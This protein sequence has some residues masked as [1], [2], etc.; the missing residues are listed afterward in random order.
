MEIITIVLSAAE[1]RTFR[2]RMQRAKGYWCIYL[3]ILYFYFYRTGVYL[4]TRLIEFKISRHTISN[5]KKNL[6]TLYSLKAFMYIYINEFSTSRIHER[7]YVL[8]DDGAVPG[9]EGTMNIAQ[10]YW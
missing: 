8:V 6:I 1:Q 4:D 10:D 3:F 2:D 9:G 7:P 5:L